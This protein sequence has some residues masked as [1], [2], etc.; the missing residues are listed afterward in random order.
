[1]TKRARGGRVLYYS[2]E[3][4]QFEQGIPGSKRRGVGRNRQQLEYKLS[5]GLPGERSESF[6]FAT[7]KEA[8][9]FAKKEGYTI[10]LT[11]PKE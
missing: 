1:M 2:R 3:W 7:K 6:D 4:W 9:A 5:D 11:T 10:K 8:Y